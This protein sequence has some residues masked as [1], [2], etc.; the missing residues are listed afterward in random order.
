MSNKKNKG[1][2]KRKQ[3]EVEANVRDL[4]GK[5]YSDFEIQEKLNL[6]PHVLRHYKKKIYDKDKINFQPTA[7]RE[8]RILVTFGGSTTSTTVRH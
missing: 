7:N 2:S 6:Q 4:I 8:D 5:N 1:Y 3:A